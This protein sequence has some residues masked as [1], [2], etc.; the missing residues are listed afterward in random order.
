M[1]TIARYNPPPRAVQKATP[2]AAMTSGSQEDTDSSMSSSD[3]GSGTTDIKTDET[4]SGQAEGSDTSS[5]DT[6]NDIQ[7][8][9]DA[10]AE[11]SGDAAPAESS[12]STES[13]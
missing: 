11:P 10:P 13:K 8:D 6:S 7:L 1:V 12:E 5:A 3:D 9:L 2:G 4:E